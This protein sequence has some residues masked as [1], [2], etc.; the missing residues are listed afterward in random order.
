VGDARRGTPGAGCAVGL[1]G[2]NA[3]RGAIDSAAYV[4]IVVAAANFTGLDAFRRTAARRLCGKIDQQKRK[5][6]MLDGEGN[7]L[8]TIEVCDDEGS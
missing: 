3:E 1:S 4:T 5:V 7:V 2:P 6:V 8:R